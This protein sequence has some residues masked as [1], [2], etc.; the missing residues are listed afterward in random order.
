METLLLIVVFVGVILLLTRVFG[1]GKLESQSAKLLTNSVCLAENAAEAVSA[2]ESPEQL[3]ELL[4][5]CGN[6]S[7]AEENGIRRIRVTYDADMTPDPGGKL[8]L[9]VTWEPNASASG[10]LVNS[11]I[12]AVYEGTEEPIYTLKTAVFLRGVSP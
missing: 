7:S 8:C 5:T 9:D 4:D 1:F 6:A 10:V 12:T 2:S 3:L 11:V